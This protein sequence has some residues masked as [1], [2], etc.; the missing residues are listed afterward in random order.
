MTELIH[1][2]KDEI[3]FFMDKSF[4]SSFAYIGALVAAVFSINLSTTQSISSFLS[5]NQYILFS[6]VI[7]LANFIFLTVN[8]GCIF[9]VVKRGIFI[10]ASFE[11]RASNPEVE[12]ETFLR[13]K[14]GR[15]GWLAWNTDNFYLVP[16]VLVVAGLSLAIFGAELRILIAAV[17][18]PK[19]AE[20]LLLVVPLALHVWPA[21]SFW[22]LGR[23]MQDYAR[24]LDGSGSAPQAERLAKTGS[25]IAKLVDAPPE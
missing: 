9:A 21:W 17:E 23:L 25:A 1:G 14:A 4:Q 13:T 10:V 8:I 11:Q 16:I 12:W 6:F 20:Y 3:R 19:P 7:L 2:I 24:L 5:I 15:L 22:Q 18:K